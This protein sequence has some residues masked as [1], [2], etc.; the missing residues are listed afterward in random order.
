MKK[1]KT[2]KTRI[3]SK[4]NRDIPF[5][6]A[7]MVYLLLGSRKNHVLAASHKIWGESHRGVTTTI[8]RYHRTSCRIAFATR[9]S[10][11]S[12]FSIDSGPFQHSKQYR[13]VHELSFGL[14]DRRELINHII[15]SPSVR[16]AS[17][18]RETSLNDEDI[19]DDNNIMDLF[20]IDSNKE[21]L[22][23]PDDFFDGKIPYPSA[24]SPSAVMEFMACPQ[25]YL[26]QYIYKIKQPPNLALAKGSMCHTALEKLFDLD[27]RDRTVKNL[28]NLLRVAWREA[29][30][31]EPYLDLFQV[32]ENKD[33]TDGEDE[34]EWD[35]DAERDWGKSALELLSN[36]YKLE[37]PRYVPDPNPLKREIW[38][39]A[40]LTVDSGNGITGY[41]KSISENDDVD[42]VSVNGGTLKSYLK[43]DTFLVRGIV[44]RIDLIS[45]PNGDT[46]L[47][48]VDYKTGKAPDFKYSPSVNRRIANE[49]FFQLKI[50][51][52]LLREM[53]AK[54]KLSLPLMDIRM[55]RLLYLTSHQEDGEAQYLDM[56]L[57][58][59][60]EGRD[61]LLQ[62]THQELATVWRRIHELVDTQDPRA[63][64]HC[65]RKFCY[66]HKVRPKFM[67][68][69]VWSR[70]PP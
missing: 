13:A 39:N 5:S 11:L 60:N 36:Y 31:K 16:F 21:P 70:S 38:V 20:E 6:I 40:Q 53:L 57:G 67:S 51:A 12:S 69:T 50:Y 45:L 30:Q 33:Q 15:R 26:F 4:I 55:L 2:T 66:C 9:K 43:K 52:L 10:T 14:Q 1:K 22:L 37:D 27:P 59:T 63:F 32:K 7:A 41:M 62:E 47:R 24:L 29:R 54:R 28:H 61:A 64:H 42:N 8:S 34:M 46:G 49:N 25:S 18:T 56:D 65:D 48:I 19:D 23:H 68:G 35:Y 3:L 17:T 58:E 44:D